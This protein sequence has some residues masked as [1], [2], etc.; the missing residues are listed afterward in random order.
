MKNKYTK[1]YL[2]LCAALLSVN[3]FYAQDIDLEAT[4]IRN[5][6]GTDGKFVVANTDESNS[7]KLLI[8]EDGEVNWYLDKQLLFVR[9]GAFKPFPTQYPD[10][11]AVYD[12]LYIDGVNGRTGMNIL[13]ETELP[14][15]SSVHIHGSIATRIR[16]IVVPDGADT[17]DDLRQDDHTV[18]VNIQGDNKVDLNLPS[19]ANC[20]GRQ[21]R[22]KRDA[23]AGKKGEVIL[24]A[25]GTELIDGANEYLIKE[26]LGVCEIISDGTQWWILSVEDDLARIT[27]DQSI[28]LS[29]DKSLVTVNF[30]S[31]DDDYII[32]LPTAAD[33]DGISFRIKR[34]AD[35][36]VYTGNTLS[37]KPSSGEYL[38]NIDNSG[39]YDMNNDF[40]SVTIISDGSRWLIIS[41]YND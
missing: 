32:T 26:T 9:D 19:A 27:V 29:G 1:F 36:N 5:T 15:T 18:I 23:L 41:A 6:M 17:S 34:N 2:F 21:Y 3:M 39:S 24:K 10:S 22:F 4:T 35:G 8:E 12:F 25:D 37:L 16:T 13:S 38:D 28:T 40:E 14:L 20:K 30:D 11:T 33:Y 7:L 31:N